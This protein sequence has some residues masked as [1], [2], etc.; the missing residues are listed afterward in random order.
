M[1]NLFGKKAQP[2]NNAPSGQDKVIETMGNMGKQIQELEDKIV[3]YENKT[4]ALNEQAKAKLKAGDKIAAKRLLA[5]KKG[6]NDQ[7]KQLDG[8]IMMI[9]EQKMI[10]ENM[11]NLQNVFSTVDNANKVIKE[12]QKLLNMDKIND[13]KDELE[14]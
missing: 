8:A 3:F 5:K 9:E 7:I 10:M 13:I 1:K 6:Y 11:Q 2:V 4:N 14:V 12:Q